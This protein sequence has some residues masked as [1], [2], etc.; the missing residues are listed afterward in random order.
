MKGLTHDCKNNE[1]SIKMKQP[2][3]KF[4]RYT[5]QK[6]LYFSGMS[7]FQCRLKNNAGH[8]NIFKKI[9]FVVNTGYF[10]YAAVVFSRDGFHKLNIEDKKRPEE[11]SA[12][13]A[14]R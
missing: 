11:K 7:L 6:I 1:T 12:F 3:V 9:L 4:S 13:F 10:W 14:M 8:I 2:I 5:E